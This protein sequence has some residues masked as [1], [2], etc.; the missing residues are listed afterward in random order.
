LRWI[1]IALCLATYW[2]AVGG[3]IV[4]ARSNTQDVFAWLCC[5]IAVL[6]WTA[7]LF[8]FEPAKEDERAWLTA[9]TASGA[10]LNGLLFA[11]AVNWLGRGRRRRRRDPQAADYDDK[12]LAP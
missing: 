6:P 2:V 7:V 12:R 8:F 5:G 4:D 11:L 3:M 10:L 9:I 1:F